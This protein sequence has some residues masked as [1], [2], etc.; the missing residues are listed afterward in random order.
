MKELFLEI[1][2]EE[3]PARFLP[4]AIKDLKE[5]LQNELQKARIAFNE[6]HTFGT[7]RR[8]VLWVPEI[9]EEQ[10]EIFSEIMG[11]RQEVAFDEQG[12][13]TKA[14]I[15]FAK[16]HGV[17]IEDL[18]EKD[19]PKGKYVCLI[20]RE[21]GESTEKL[22]EDIL[23]RVILSIPFPKS[24]RWEELEIRFARPI[25]WIV[26][27]F[28]GKKIPFS[29]GNVKSDIFSYG[30]PLLSPAPFPVKDFLS[31]LAKCRESFVIVSPEERKEM[32]KKAI[33][34]KA[35]EVKG[36][37]MEDET[38]L[39]EVVNMVEYPQAI[40]GTFGEEF[41]SLPKE[42]L[43]A[44][45]RGQ[46]KF[47]PLMDSEVGKLLPHFIGISNCPT[48]NPVKIRQGYER[49]LRARLVDAQFFF[50]ADSAVPLDRRVE[51]LKRVVYQAKLGTSYEKVM[52]FHALSAFLAERL[53][54]DKIELIKRVAYL[55]KA[56][57]VTEMV[58]EFP[59]LQ[60]IMGKEYALASRENPDVA[61]AIAD[62]H[63]PVSSEGPL[64]STLAGAIVGLADRIDTIVGCFGIGLQPT[65]TADPYALRRH[66]LSI[67]RIILGKGFSL[68]LKEIIEKSLE[69][70]QDKIYRKREEVKEDVMNFLG[71]R[72]K[73]LLLTWEFDHEIVEGTL[74]ISFD[75]PLEAF[76][77]VKALSQ[78]K[79]EMNFESLV[80]TFKRVANIAREHE[81]SNLLKTQ[82]LIEPQEKI[83]FQVFSSIESKA[84]ELIENKDYYQALLEI[85]KLKKPVDDFFD[86]VLVMT[87]VQE[88]RENRLGL[89]KRISNLFNR[90]AD[91]T[92]L[93]PLQSQ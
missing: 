32:I 35:Q 4:A 2:T 88:L 48:E 17:R 40:M 12:N 55:C 86:K 66:A 54:A 3:I 77:K 47:F 26:A 79:K 22:L 76:Q 39:E 23:P 7:P 51:D 80:K 70:L 68:S 38:L 46:Q 73:N 21:G 45:M 29:I 82:L 90:I 41:L 63:L 74:S 71:Q 16:S 58:K 62:H 61:E 72:F 8:L 36:K 57:L 11:P 15:G 37:V 44:C 81:D 20:R 89:L 43:V 53:A 33:E 6:I 69:L 52:R 10:E 28:H 64:P 92:K 5:I 30:H 49:V 78:F 85:A 25:R 19:T 1:G 91:F 24:M 65:G 31:Y 50:S 13:P 9:A 34:G 84:L 14:A 93:L 18:S 87:E 60:G 75:N 56:D 67:L 59:E 83:L 27:I 42:V